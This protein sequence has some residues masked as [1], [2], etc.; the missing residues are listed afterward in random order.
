MVMTGNNKDQEMEKQPQST[1]PPQRAG[2]KCPQCGTFIDTNIYQ[3]IH[4]RALVCPKCGLCLNIDPVKSKAAIDA[5]KKVQAAQDNLER[6]SH[7]N[8]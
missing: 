4:A 2:L 8:R 6:K 1:L 3:I 5:L 7:F